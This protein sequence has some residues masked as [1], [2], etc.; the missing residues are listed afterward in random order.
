MRDNVQT[1][2]TVGGERKARLNIVSG[3]VGEIV[4]HFGNGHAATEVIENVRHGDARATDAGLAAA[5]ARVNRD[6]FPVVHVE[7]VVLWAG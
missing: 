3:E 5:D 2:V 7:T 4:K 1:A 6:A